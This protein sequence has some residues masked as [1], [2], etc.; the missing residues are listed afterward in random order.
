[1]RTYTTYPVLKNY[2]LIFVIMLITVSVQSQAPVYR[3]KNPTLTTPAGTAGQVNAVYRFPSV[4]TGGTNI[5]ALVKIKS[6][7]GNISLQNIDRTADGYDEAFQPEYRI[8]AATNAYF[9]F[10]ITF[11]LAGTSTPAPQPLV[12]VSALDIDGSNSGILTLKEFNRVDMGG[13]VCTFNTLGSQLT[14]SQIGS[15]YDGSNFTGILFGALVDTAA[16]EVMFSVS[17]ANITSFTYRV[18]ANTLLPSSSSRYASLYFKKF[19]YPTGSVLSAPNLAS[20]NGVAAGGKTKLSWVLTENNIADN[21]VLEKSNNGTD[22]QSIVEF[23]VNTDGN[24]QRDF[25][26]SDNKATQAT[27]Y[28]RLKVTGK[29]GK[30]QYSNVILFR[31]QQ[32]EAGTIAIYPSVVQSLTTVSFTSREKQN[33]VICVTDMTGRT[34]KRQNILLQ[35]GTNNIQVAGFD[36]FQKGNYIVSVHTA[37]EK[38][39]RQ[40]TVQ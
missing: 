20:F 7:V 13:G 11:V 40:I 14:L 22:F 27:V 23:W 39:A 5:D 21:V 36:Q 12:D 18:G 30:I 24:T 9:E 33:A 6:K 29:D 38:A 15:A 4:K 19:T 1:M 28:Y 3:F 17:N 2:L 35:A 34:V 8:G 10:L 25:T 32:A 37:Q 31:N 16:K 26:Y